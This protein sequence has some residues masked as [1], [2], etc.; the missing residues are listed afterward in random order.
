MSG[1]VYAADPPHG[2]SGWSRRIAVAV[3]LVVVTGVIWGAFKFVGNGPPAAKRQV[4]RI[5][6]LPDVPPPPPPPPPRAKIEPKTETRQQQLDKPKL[7]TPP[8]PPVVKMEGQ[9]GDGP[10]PFAAGEVRNDYIGGDVGAGSRYAGYVGRVAQLVQEELAR[11]NLRIASARVFLWLR[12]DGTVDRYE[13]SGVGSDI[14]RGIRS[15]MAGVGRFP[16]APPP[17][18]PMPMGLEISQR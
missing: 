7:D 3:V 13:V 18:M 6:L 10:S 1:L 16:E 2:G 9:A 14:E 8:A 4:A 11:R 17:D 5:A 15:A 12:A